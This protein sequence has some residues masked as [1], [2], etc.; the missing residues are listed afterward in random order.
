LNVHG[1]FNFFN[2][3][4]MLKNILNLE[5]AQQLS[6]K[7]QNTIHGGGGGYCVSTCGTGMPACPEGSACVQTW[8]ALVTFQGWYNVCYSQSGDQ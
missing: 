3:F 4:I 1:K 7:E 8:C 5:G 2:F 6:K